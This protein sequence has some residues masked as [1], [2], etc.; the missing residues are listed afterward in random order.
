MYLT[1]LLAFLGG[2]VI[3]FPVFRSKNCI[4]TLVEQA[5]ASEQELREEAAKLLKEPELGGEAAKLVTGLE[6][7]K[8]AAE[9][10]KEP[11]LEEA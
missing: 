5:E 8:E 11:E 1:L 9:S 3:T 10:L 2:F 7:G 4:A 6:P